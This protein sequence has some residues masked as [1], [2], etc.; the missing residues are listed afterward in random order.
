MGVLGGLC[1]EGNREGVLGKGLPEESKDSA[2]C[3]LVDGVQMPSV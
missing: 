1:D 2:L 3:D